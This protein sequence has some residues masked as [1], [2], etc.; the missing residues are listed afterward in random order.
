MN[1][2]DKMPR[3]TISLNKKEDDMLKDLSEKEHRS[4][5]QQIVHMMEFYLNHRKRNR[6]DIG[7]LTELSHDLR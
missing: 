7:D 5:S 1:E 6:K 3:R 2:D 4:C